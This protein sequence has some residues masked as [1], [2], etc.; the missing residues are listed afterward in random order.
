MS[1]TPDRPTV[2]GTCLQFATASTSRVERYLLLHLALRA[3]RVNITDLFS[4]PVAHMMA[5]S[6]APVIAKIVDRMMGPAPVPATP[7]PNN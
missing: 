4:T 2:H 1:T 6:L 7:P 5:V 3:E